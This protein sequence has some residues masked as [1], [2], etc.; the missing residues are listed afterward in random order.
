M[1]ETTE[2]TIAEATAQDLMDRFSAEHLLPGESAARQGTTEGCVSWR[3]RPQDS[4]RG[5]T[6]G[7]SR[8]I[9][10]GNP[11]SPQ[12]ARRRLPRRIPRDRHECAR[13]RQAELSGERR[14]HHGGAPRP[15]LRTRLRRPRGPAEGGRGVF[16]SGPPGSRTIS[17]RWPLEFLVGHR[18]MRTG[19]S[20]SSAGAALS[21]RITGSC[22]RHARAT[23]KMPK[24]WMGRH[25]ERAP[26]RGQSGEREEQH[27]SQVRGRQAARV[28]KRAT[29]RPYASLRAGARVAPSLDH[30]R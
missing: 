2:I 3:T 17:S 25:D 13:H 11:A 1:N 5:T 12:A 14:G 9:R 23:S 18:H 26:D 24:S 15:P 20:I 8:R 28:T 7:R 4:S 19:S 29:P 6:G 21:R 27:R 30:P 22:N 10:V 16:S